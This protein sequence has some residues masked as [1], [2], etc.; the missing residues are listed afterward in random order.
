[1]ARQPTPLSTGP[2][3]TNAAQPITTNKEQDPW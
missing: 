2:A 3:A 1:L